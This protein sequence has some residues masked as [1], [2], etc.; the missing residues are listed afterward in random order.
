MVLHKLPSVLR[1]AVSTPA[2]PTPSSSP[3]GEAR[4]PRGPPATRRRTVSFGFNDSVRL[5]VVGQCYLQ[6]KPLFESRILMLWRVGKVQSVLLTFGNCLKNT[7]VC[8][9]EKNN[10]P[11]EMA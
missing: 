10:P 6:Q 8:S 9:F 5:K 7:E 4:R 11:P 3:S 2:C 1:E